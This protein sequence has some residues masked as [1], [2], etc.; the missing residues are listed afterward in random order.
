MIAEKETGRLLP[1]G[2]YAR[3]Q[4][5]FNRNKNKKVFVGVSGGVD[6]AVA[7]A[8]LKKK[9]IRSLVFLLRHGLLIL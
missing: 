7:L 4:K 2:I 9:D 3:W 1:A 6:S 5:M 8:R